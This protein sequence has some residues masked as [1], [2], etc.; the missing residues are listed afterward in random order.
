MRIC[1]I[2]SQSDCFRMNQGNEVIGHHLGPPNETLRSHTELELLCILFDLQVFEDLHSKG[3]TTPEGTDVTIEA[4][5]YRL[6]KLKHQDNAVFCLPLLKEINYILNSL[7]S[8]SPLRQ[9]LH[10]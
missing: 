6:R 9:P 1:R 8:R 2:L 10:F 3:L 5:K 4:I 7:G